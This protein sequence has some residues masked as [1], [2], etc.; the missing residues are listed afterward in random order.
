MGC[1]MPN[2]TFIV[3]PSTTR[4]PITRTSIHSSVANEY[5]SGLAVPLTINSNNWEIANADEKIQQKIFMVLTRP[6]GST[7]GR[8]D[9]GS[10]IPNRVFQLLSSS[11]YGEIEK[12]A[13]DALVRWV[14]EITDVVARVV[15][16]QNLIESG[17]LA[18]A[19]GFRVRGVNTV[20]NVTINYDN[21][22]TVSYI[23]KSNYAIGNR[24]VFQ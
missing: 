21:K 9:F 10:T 20:N 14:P 23:D 15:E 12:D 16:D 22:K 19:I 8:P 17:I 3:A 18:L 13:E 5:G 6:L 1:P 4:V 24:G 2:S 11:Y 7:F